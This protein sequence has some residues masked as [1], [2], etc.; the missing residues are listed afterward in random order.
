MRWSSFRPGLRAVVVDFVVR[1]TFDLLFDSLLMLPCTDGWVGVKDFLS[2]IVQWQISLRWYLLVQGLPVAVLAVA[3]GLNILL[4]AP[5]PMWER[6]P[7]L[8][9]LPIGRCAR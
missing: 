4:G 5:A 1:G 3:V 6:V 8:V 2:R 9:E 7:P